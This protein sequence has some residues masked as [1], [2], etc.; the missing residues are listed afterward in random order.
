MFGFCKSH[1]DI[2]IEHLD[3]KYVETCKD[4]NK[5]QNILKILRSGDEGRY[6]LLEEY[7]EQ[8]L[9]KYKPESYLL[10]K[11]NREKLTKDLPKDE[12]EVLANNLKDFLSEENA[13]TPLKDLNNTSSNLPPVRSAKNIDVQVSNEQKLKSDSKKETKRA[14]PRSYDEWAKIDKDLDKDEDT[15]ENKENHAI[16]KTVINKKPKAH[17]MLEKE[18]FVKQFEDSTVSEKQSAAQNEKNKG[19]EA[20]YCGDFLE[21]LIYYNRSLSIYSDPLVYNNRAITNIK[22]EKYDDALK[23][24]DIVID[25]DP[26][27]IKAYLRRGIAYQSLNQLEKALC[28]FTKVVEVEPKNKRG[29]ELYEKVYKELEKKKAAVAKKGKRLIIEEI[30][31][32]DGETIQNNINENNEPKI[33]EVDSKKIQL[34][35][36]TN[37]NSRELNDTK[38]ASTNPDSTDPVKHSGKKINIVETDS[39]CDTNQKLLNESLNNNELNNSNKKP[40]TSSEKTENHTID[41]KKAD[42]HNI[43][44]NTDTNTKE[45]SNIIKTIETVKPV[46][47]VKELPSNV[48]KIKDSGNSHFRTGAYP[49]ACEEYTFAIHQL[50]EDPTGH[51]ASLAT[52]FSNRAACHM[53]TG[54]CQQCIK[55]CNKSIGFYPTAKAYQRRATAYET[56]EKYLNAY[57]DFQTALKFDSSL[58]AA[59]QGCSRL[60]N[61]LRKE[62]GSN[63]REKLPK[64]LDTPTSSYSN[65]QVINNNS[66]KLTNSANAELVQNQATIKKDKLQKETTAS[67]GKKEVDG[68]VSH[69]TKEELKETSQREQTQ[70]NDITEKIRELQKEKVFSKSEMEREQTVEE[71]FYETKEQGNKYVKQGKYREAASF[72]TLCIKLLPREVPSYTNRALCYLKMEMPKDAHR[73]CTT[74]LSLQPTNVKA[75]FRRAQARKILKEYRNALSDLSVILKIEPKNSAA[76][77]ESD[78]CK[79]LFRTELRDIQERNV[80]TGEKKS[81]KIDIEEV[82]SPKQSKP[83]GKMSTKAATCP[84]AKHTAKTTIK[85]KKMTSYEFFRLLSN[86]KSNNSSLFADVLRQIEAERFP[87]LL[88]NK[89]DGEL[90][91]KFIHALHDHFTDASTYRQGIQLLKHLCRASRFTTASM[92]LSKK[93]KSVFKQTVDKLKSHIPKDGDTSV[94]LLEDVKSI[95]VPL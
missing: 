72:Y 10:E 28:D 68:N 25:H 7:T 22:L 43:T 51:E 47:V 58:L 45:N 23:D 69:P 56:V 6:P 85:T 36:L 55:D 83:S 26:N 1:P 92:M 19:N 29:K 24:A 4:A 57:A 52:L 70:R 12:K 94:A 91:K 80:N 17:E 31:S 78:L 11:K 27:N 88:S 30:D 81:K 53:K 21:A 46:Y 15:T 2:P 77:K 14:L 37:K 73:D 87:E 8:Q 76:K 38:L 39:S 18:N 32:N 3:Y 64:Q 82:T 95:K 54:S 41:D 60:S 40:N 49:E 33:T 42:R 48:I 65:L 63:W 20:F 66:V 84:T 9:A 44:D 34:D 86:I 35:H 90:L 71:Q 13:T 61:L 89:L 93:E 79:D 16:D 50:M 74:A 59:S 62:Y 5:L 67:S 75:L